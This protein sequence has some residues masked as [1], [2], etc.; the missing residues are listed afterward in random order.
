MHFYRGECWFHNMVLIVFSDLGTPF[1]FKLWFSVYLLYI[2]WLPQS[3]RLLKVNL[4][5][6]SSPHHIFLWNLWQRNIYFFIIH[7]KLPTIIFYDI[8][9]L[10]ELSIFQYIWWICYFFINHI[11]FNSFSITIYGM[12]KSSSNSLFNHQKHFDIRYIR[13]LAKFLIL[14][15]IQILFTCLQYD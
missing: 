14:N 8:S 11:L 15:L 12:K 7:L 4:N 1:S 5:K 10:C 9:H 6:K 13:Y 3:F 2:M